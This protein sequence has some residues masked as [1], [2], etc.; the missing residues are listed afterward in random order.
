MTIESTYTNT[1]SDYIAEY[2]AKGYKL[3]DRTEDTAQMV[4]PK[5][6]SAAWAILWFLL[7]GIGLVVYILYYLGKR[8]TIIMLR[9]T[10]AGVEINGGAATEIA[11]KEGMSA[12]NRY[13]IISGFI[14]VVSFYSM[15]ST[16]GATGM[17]IE[18]FV[19]VVAAAVAVWF[20]MPKPESAGEVEAEER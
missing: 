5:V 19:G 14:A 1:L 15:L 20:F 2:S 13:A 3:T 7:F 10:E 16:S 8:D 6:F 18:A 9:E 17:I 12:N 4:K 11:H